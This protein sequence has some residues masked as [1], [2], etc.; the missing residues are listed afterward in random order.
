MAALT[1]QGTIN[2]RRQVS[3]VASTDDAI[4]AGDACIVVD[5]TKT[6][7]QIMEAIRGIIKRINRDGLKKSTPAGYGTSG[8]TLE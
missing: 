4:G 8:T 2:K 6:K 5:S 1:Y 3:V 7:S